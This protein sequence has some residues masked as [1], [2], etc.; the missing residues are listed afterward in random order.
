MAKTKEKKNYELKV[1]DGKYTFTILKTV[2]GKGRSI[3]GTY[4]I[5]C[6]TE[7]GV[8]RLTRKQTEKW[9]LEIAIENGWFP[10]ADGK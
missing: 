1:A 2:D 4:P 5:V 3:V 7:K 9:C 8:Q 10:A 6:Q